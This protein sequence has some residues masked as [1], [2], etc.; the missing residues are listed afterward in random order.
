E[1]ASIV[2]IGPVTA[3]A[4]REL[5]LVPAAVADEHTVDGLIQEL[6]RLELSDA[7]V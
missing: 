5:G 1:N 6:K 4:V 7:C 2:C 3:D